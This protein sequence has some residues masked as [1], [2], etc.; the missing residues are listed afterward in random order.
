MIAAIDVHTFL[1]IGDNNWTAFFFLPCLTD[2]QL[3]KQLHVRA[4]PIDSVVYTV[5]R[6]DMVRYG[7]YIHTVVRMDMVH[8]GTKWYKRQEE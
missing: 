2:A 1:T 7:T 8:Y 4:S 6:M 5:V 3:P